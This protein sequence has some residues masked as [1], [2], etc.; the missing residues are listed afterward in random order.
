MA[1]LTVQEIDNAGLTPTFDSAASGGDVFNNSGRTF[2]YV[3]NGDGSPHDVT[4]SLN[5]TITIGGIELTISDPT[6]TVAAGDNTMIGPFEKGWYDDSNGQVN[7]NYDGV[8]SV[9]VAAIKL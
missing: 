6:I 3:K 1:E 5:K 4:I 9:E 8:T 2:L 7:V